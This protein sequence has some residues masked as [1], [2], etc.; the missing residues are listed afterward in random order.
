[1]EAQVFTRHS[2]DC[3][4]QSDR[5]YRRCRC[6][7]W[8]YLAGTRKRIPANTRSWDQAVR[9]AREMEEEALSPGGCRVSEA[10]SLFIASKEQQNSSKDWVDKFRYD[11]KQLVDFFKTT[12]SIKV[13]DVSLEQLE[14]FRGTWKGASISRSKRQE[15]LRQFFGY[16]L[17]HRWCTENVAASLSRIKV[18]MPETLPL[19]VEQFEA[20]LK[21][22]DTYHPRGK[23]GDWRRRRAR[24]MLLLCRHSGLRISDAAKLERVR[25]LDNDSLLLRTA[26]TGKHVYVPLPSFVARMLRELENSNPRYFFWNGTSAAETPGKLWWSTLKRIFKA[27]GLP[28]SHPH[29]LRDTFAVECLLGG[30]DIKKVSVML[31]HSSVAIT[32]R[33]YLPWVLARQT[34][35]EE[36]MRRM[37]KVSGKRSKATAAGKH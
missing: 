14:K 22:A 10:V 4:H 36:S 16:C 12:P 6:R 26:K 7:K 30:I 35:L 25:L 29:C 18:D 19:T 34:D 23:D 3:S 13:H 31:G 5:F 33:H 11:L 17:K 27:A 1:M 32:E 24:A 8:I 20:A 21:A 28:D 2:S 37:W 9:K 15:R